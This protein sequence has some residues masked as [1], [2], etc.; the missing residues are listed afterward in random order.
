MSF[1]EV[2][3]DEVCFHIFNQLNR[4][5]LFAASSV[6]RNWRAFIKNYPD[7]FWWKNMPQGKSSLCSNTS[8]A[9]T[10]EKDTQISDLLIGSNGII[11]WVPRPACDMRF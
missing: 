4:K 5:E 6:C 9:H 7:L 3:P 11:A 10:R 2:F 1:A 8:L